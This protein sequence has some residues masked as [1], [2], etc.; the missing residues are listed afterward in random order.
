MPAATP[1]ICRL[2][3]IKVGATELNVHFRTVRLTVEDAMADVDTF[4]NPEGEAPSSSKWTFEVDALQSFGPDSGNAGL[5][6]QFR[7]WAKTKQTFIVTPST[8]AVSVTNPKATFDAWV[9][10]TNFLDSARGESTVQTITM[11]VIGEP[12]FVT[13]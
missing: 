6:D 9:P 10:S 11:S 7:P 3:S 4:V 1:Y 5:W 12:A 13:V 2:P 8:A